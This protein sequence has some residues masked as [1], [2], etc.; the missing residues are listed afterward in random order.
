MMWWDWAAAGA[1]LLGLC[2]L[3]GTARE[4]FMLFAVGALIARVL[5][6]AASSVGT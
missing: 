1:V 5:Y 6:L 2:M 3:R 4:L